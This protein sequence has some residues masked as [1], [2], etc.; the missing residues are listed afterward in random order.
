MW[1]ADACGNTTAASQTITV[2]DTTPPVLSGVPVD[3]AVDGDCPNR[4]KLTRTWT[5]TDACGNS[6]SASQVITGQDT[7][8]PQLHD[9]TA[10][11]GSYDPNV[12][13]AA[14]VTATDNCESNVTVTFSEARRGG[15]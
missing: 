8:T 13:S 10:S 4:Y 5:A 7:T 11:I 12:P 3:S 9:V 15:N 2:M 1:A 14:T 6:S